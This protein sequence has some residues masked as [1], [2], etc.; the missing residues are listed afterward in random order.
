LG[1]SERKKEE[2]EKKGGGGKPV[3]MEPFLSE[4]KNER[5]PSLNTIQII[6]IIITKWVFLKVGNFTEHE[7][8]KLL[9]FGRYSQVKYQNL[10]I[11]QLI[12]YDGDFEEALRRAGFPPNTASENLESIKTLLSL[13]SG[14]DHHTWT[15]LVTCLT[16]CSILSLIFVA[17]RFY[18][19]LFLRRI[20]IRPEDWII[21][22]GLYL[23]ISFAVTAIHLYT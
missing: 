9:W 7:A 18:S 20:A 12:N 16:V 13:L 2:R 1:G 21:L 23:T 14:N 22:A 11:A 17:L 15:L 4:F 10:T 19:R 6:S 8:E 3:A 5:Y